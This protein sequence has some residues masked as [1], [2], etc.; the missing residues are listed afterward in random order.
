MYIPVY[1]NVRLIYILDKKNSY[2]SMEISA[3]VWVGMMVPI[4]CWDDE[5][6]DLK[7]TVPVKAT[8]MVVTW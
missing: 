1:Y 7:E 8:T 2:I 4:R 6:N 3:N 5:I